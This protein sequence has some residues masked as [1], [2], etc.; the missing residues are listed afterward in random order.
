MDARVG[1]LA[2][3][4]ER[5]PP[6]RIPMT[7][8]RAEPYPARHQLARIVKQARAVLRPPGGA[9][10]RLERGSGAHQLNSR[11]YF[12]EQRRRQFL[13]E[14]RGLVVG[15]DPVQ[16]PLFGVAEVQAGASRG[17]SRH[18]KGAAPLRA[19]PGRSSNAGEETARLPGR[20][21]TRP[22]T[23]GPW[24]MQRH[25]LHAVVPFAPLGLAGLQHRV[26]EERSSGVMGLRLG[27]QSRAPR[28]QFHQV[29]D[30]ALAGDHPS[31]LRLMLDQAAVC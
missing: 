12:L 3:Q 29:L 16:A 19:S 7:H 5:R 25:H 28:H 26:R 30:A 9:R 6:R 23:P 22:E 11:P 27:L 17:S 14:A 4:V 18:N 13:D 2:F 24:R 8:A 20:T 31:L 1:T 21:G 10:V 15:I